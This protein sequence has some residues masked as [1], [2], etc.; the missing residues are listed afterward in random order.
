MTVV[1]GER[2]DIGQ[3]TMIGRNVTIRDN[4]GGHYINRVGY[5]NSRPVIIG[6]KAWLCEQ[7]TIMPGVKIG[8]GAIIGANSVVT[9]D[10]PPYAIVG[11]VPAKVIRYRYDEETIRFL[12]D[13]KWWNKDVEWLRE[14]WELL[15]D[16]DKLKVYCK[17][18]KFDEGC[19]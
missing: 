2:I 3:H 18:E 15:C 9:K 13:L 16:I 4:N 5:R 10:V 12:L 6:E 8:N 11:G 17:N 14:N 7:S 1:C 19:K